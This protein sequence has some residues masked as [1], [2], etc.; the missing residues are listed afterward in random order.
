MLGNK[1][2]KLL[3]DYVNHFAIPVFFY[4]KKSYPKNHEVRDLDKKLDLLM[5]HL[6]GRQ[7]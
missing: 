7:R 1:R 3:K 6:T 4:K 2:G 5:L